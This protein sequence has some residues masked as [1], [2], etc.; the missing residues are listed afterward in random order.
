MLRAFAVDGISF[1]SFHSL[2]VNEGLGFIEW[3]GEGEDGKGKA[4]KAH[5]VHKAKAYQWMSE[6]GYQQTM[7]Q[8]YEMSK[9]SFE[10]MANLMTTSLQDWLETRDLDPEAYDYIK[11]LAAAPCHYHPHNGKAKLLVIL[12]PPG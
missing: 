10:D 12:W 7:Q 5:Q 4:G 3:Q 9:S 11:V 1:I 2:K 6:E 8:M